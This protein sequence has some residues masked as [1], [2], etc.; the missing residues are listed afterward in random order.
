MNVD[1]MF[2]DCL[3]D[4]EFACV[5]Q[6]PDPAEA[7]SNTIYIRPD[8]SSYICLADGDYVALGPISTDSP[9]SELEVHLSNCPNCGAPLVKGKCEY[10]GTEVI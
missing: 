7:K 5:D 1:Q 3:G 4:L 9:V 8:K 10:C 6:L 2:C